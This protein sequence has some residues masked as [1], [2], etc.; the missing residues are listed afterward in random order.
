MLDAELKVLKPDS[1]PPSLRTLPE[2][3]NITNEKALVLI[4]S[5]HALLKEY[6]AIGM[7]DENELAAKFPAEFPKKIKTFLFKM[8]REVAEPSKVYL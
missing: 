7:Q 6:I 8:M 3:L 5:L 1:L 2:T 4:L